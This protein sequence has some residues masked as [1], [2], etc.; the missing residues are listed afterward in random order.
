M[1]TADAGF[2]PSGWGVHYPLAS[3]AVADDTEDPGSFFEG[4]VEGP[5]LDGEER[6][7]DCAECHLDDFDSIE[8][9]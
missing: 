5:L 9:D 7:E 2:Y 1:Q 3:D 8:I 6:G 4:V